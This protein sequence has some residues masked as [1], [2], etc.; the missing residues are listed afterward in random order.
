MIQNKCIIGLTGGIATGKSEVVKILKSLG[1]YVIDSDKVAHRVLELPEVLNKIKSTF[2]EEVVVNNKVQRNILGEKVFGNEENLKVLNEITH[3]VIIKNI[4]FEINSIEDDIIFVDIPLL[5]ESKD[6]FKESNLNFSSIWLV[7]INKDLQVE[8]LMA[9]DGID[10]EYAKRKISSQMSIDDK[11]KYADV[12]INNEG[13]RT[14]L[15]KQI[16]D[17]LKK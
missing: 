1:Y 7:Y 9:R 11:V 4:I 8:R 16:L 2:G 10:E 14:K 6:T 17:Q 13:N 5:I 12:I 3:P 15:K